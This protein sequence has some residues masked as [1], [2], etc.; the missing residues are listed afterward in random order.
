MPPASVSRKRLSD[1]SEKR[2]RMASEEMLAAEQHA[3]Y[4]AL[5]YKS[6]V[7]GPGTSA[8]SMLS[9]S[10]KFCSVSHV[11]TY[12]SDRYYDQQR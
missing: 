8:S 12:S 4:G 5:Y 2:Y 7:S 6:C 11:L 1:S 10:L 9:F 3:L